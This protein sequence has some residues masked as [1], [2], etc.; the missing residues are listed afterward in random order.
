MRRSKREGRCAASPRTYRTY[1]HA[2]LTQQRSSPS[3][4]PYK[5]PY[6]GLATVPGRLVVCTYTQV[7]RQKCGYDS[8]TGPDELYAGGRLTGK[9]TS[10]QLSYLRYN[11]ELLPWYIK[12]FCVWLCGRRRSQCGAR[13]PRRFSALYAATLRRLALL[14]IVRRA[15]AT[16]RFIY[17]SASWCSRTSRSC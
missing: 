10:R 2:L 13:E 3:E 6:E 12:D 4:R 8:T 15:K 11:N 16:F 5:L 7:S 1:R 14:H 9:K 17:G